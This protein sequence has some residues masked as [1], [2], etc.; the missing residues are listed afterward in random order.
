MVD[1]ATST[2]ITTLSPT[3]PAGLSSSNPSI[4]FNKIDDP[5][6]S[7]A[8][9]VQRTRGRPRRPATIVQLEEPASEPYRRLRSRQNPSKEISQDPWSNLSKTPAL[10]PL[11]PKKNRQVGVFQHPRQPPVN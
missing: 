4:S 10:T 1:P 11:S 7:P 2:D 9:P 8:S 5:F 6:Q 3:L